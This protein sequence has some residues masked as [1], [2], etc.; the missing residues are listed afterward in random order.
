MNA[1]H[2]PVA[3]LADLSPFYVTVAT[4][5]QFPR[6]RNVVDRECCPQ[7]PESDSGYGCVDW[8]QYRVIERL[9]TPARLD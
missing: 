4:Q 1:T 5:E 2:R 3:R 8:Y 6:D 7:R 9:Q